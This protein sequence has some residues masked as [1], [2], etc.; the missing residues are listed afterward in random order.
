[1][2]VKAVVSS[3]GLD[4]A[5]NDDR[6]G[7]VET[8]AGL[9]AWV[10]DGATNVAARDYLDAGQGDVPWYAQA[11]SDALT[12][13]APEGL[14]PRALH[15]AAARDV[16]TAYRELLTRL[17]E[18]PPLHAQPM[19]ALVL[20]RIAGDTADLFELGDCPAFD[21]RGDVVGRLTAAVKRPDAV[22]ATAGIAAR[23]AEIGHDAKAIW[24]DRLPALQRERDLQLS[25]S[26]LRVS[27]PAAG[28]VFGGRENALDL[29]GVTALVLMSDGYERFAANYALGDDAA[30]IQRTVAEGPERLLSEIRALEAGDPDCRRI[31][32]LKPSDD[33]TCLVLA[34]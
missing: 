13:H 1:M 30:M 16:S 5:E 27:T 8:P 23:Q 32:R 9:Y 3:V 34:P 24:H 20:V 25:R 19:A 15:E 22:E 21:L 14:P 18:P 26:P 10:I 7:S 33:A 6:A 11:L 17:A 31:P 29:A 12:A 28:A 4:S 2:R